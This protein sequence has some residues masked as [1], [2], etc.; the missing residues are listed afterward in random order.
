[1]FTTWH[2]VGGASLT[3]KPQKRLPAHRSCLPSVASWHIPPRVHLH[4]IILATSCAAD[5]SLTLFKHSQLSQSPG[6]RA[7]RGV[8]TTRTQENQSRAQGQ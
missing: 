8:G 5:D 4:D 7:T 6:T 1:M 2:T 3:S